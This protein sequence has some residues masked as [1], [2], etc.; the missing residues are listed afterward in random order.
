MHTRH[1]HFLLRGLDCVRGEW[2]LV[3]LEAISGLRSAAALWR[4]PLLA[5]CGTAGARSR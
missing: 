3:V 4:P 2:S 1:R 5:R